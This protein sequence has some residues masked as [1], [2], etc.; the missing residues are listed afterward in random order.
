V[1]NLRKGFDNDMDFF[2]STSI[3]EGGNLIKTT[4]KI[5]SLYDKIY[6]KGAY[7]KIPVSKK[8]EESKA[9]VDINVS[10]D[11]SAE[12]LSKEAHERYKKAKAKL[13]RYGGTTTHYGKG[14]AGTVEKKLE[15]K[16]KMKKENEDEEKMNGCPGS[17][18]RSKGK[19]RGLGIGGG[20]G[21]IGVPVGSK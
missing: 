16:E 21:P 13:A 8:A 11:E 1:E 17:K 2:K 4:G 18:I 7:A 15:K 9:K 10:P 19:G 6:G 5:R 12:Y 20:K 14:I 3:D